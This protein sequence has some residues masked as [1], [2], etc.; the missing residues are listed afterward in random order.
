MHCPSCYL[1]SN[2]II[3][4]DYQHLSAVAASSALWV[5]L[6]LLDSKD[7]QNSSVCPTCVGLIS[8]AAECF[9]NHNCYLRYCLPD[10]FMY[11]Q[12]VLFF[13]LCLQLLPLSFWSHPTWVLHSSVS[14]SAAWILIL[15]SLPFCV[16]CTCFTFTLFEESTFR[17][18][19][20]G[21]NCKQMLRTSLVSNIFLPFLF[22]H[23]ICT[24][25]GTSPQLTQITLLTSVPLGRLMP[26]KEQAFQG[27]LKAYT[28]TQAFTSQIFRKT[29]G[30]TF[31]ADLTFKA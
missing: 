13:Y 22:S 6:I 15:T 31:T 29:L 19:P 16:H 14:L 7:L 4:A 11:L 17:F 27:M 2:V 10:T 25:H 23:E 3:C 12:G 21:A 9:T 30:L 1:T 5:A 24:P 18:Q 26:A 8:I 20:K 28:F